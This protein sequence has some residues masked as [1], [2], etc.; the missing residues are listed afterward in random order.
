M[1]KLGKTM[2]NL[3]LDTK[4]GIATLEPKGDIEQADF[5][6]ITKAID[7]YLADHDHLKGVIV[8]SKDFPHWA[9]FGALLS[10][11]KFVKNHHQKIEKLALVTDS[12]LGDFAEKVVSHFIHA[13]VKH[14]SNDN[15]DE[16]KKWVTA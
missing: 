1:A 10:H 3:T 4:N 15:L 9:N 2:L 8:H 16:A 6:D 12:V 14:F 11:L 7:D 13:E 5:A